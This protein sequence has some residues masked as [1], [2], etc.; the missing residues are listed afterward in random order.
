MTRRKALFCLPAAGA[1]GFAA[2][3]TESRELVKP[4][5]LR[6]GDTV[7]I[8]SP[9]TQVTDPDRLQMAQRTV[10]YFGLKARWGKS[11][12]SHRAQDVATV[13]ERVDD[14][15]GLFKDSDVR[16]IFCIRGGYGACQLLADLDY[17]LIRRNP[18]IFVGYSDITALHLAFQR[19]AGLVTFHGP[20]LLSEFSPYTQANF[21][22]AL[23]DKVALG[24][25]ANPVETNVLR[26]NHPVRTIRSGTARGRLTGGNLTLIS[27]L[28]GTPY[29][30]ET[31][32]RL[33][34]TE[35][36]GEEPY[37]IDRMLTQLRLAGKLKVV[38]GIMF[39]ECHECSPNDYKPSFAWNR[40]FGVV[41]DDRLQD[42]GVPVLSGLTIGHTGDQLTLPL[43][44]MAS[45]DADKAILNVEEAAVV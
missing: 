4:P 30:I 36:V 22:K 24:S 6:A 9:S 41:L 21:R 40:T 31:E 43:G 13:S 45:L 25:L 18:K 2:T 44:V 1:S 20:V 11:V 26:P 5:A 28:M 8:L 23:F 42:V 17:E 19:K 35:D 15:H 7:G 38:A 27:T 10:D 12:R 37:R 32:Q 33:F 39:G 3:N 16:A 29:E 34:F 14:L